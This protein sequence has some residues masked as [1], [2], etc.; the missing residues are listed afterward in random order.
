VSSVSYLGNY[1]FGSAVNYY[2][3]AFAR[4][5]QSRRLMDL[6]YLRLIHHLALTQCRTGHLQQATATA[7]EGINADPDN[8][9]FYYDLACVA[10]RSRDPIGAL[11]NLRQALDLQDNVPSGAEAMD[12]RRDEAF[13]RLFRDPKFR[14]ELRSKLDSMDR[15]FFPVPGS[16]DRVAINLSTFSPTAWDKGVTDLTHFRKIDHHYAVD[17]EVTVQASHGPTS[18]S[19]CLDVFAKHPQ[20]WQHVRTETL[21]SGRVVA[22]L[23]YT[24]LVRTYGEAPCDLFTGTFFD[25]SCEFKKTLVS[26][27]ALDSA[28]AYVVFSTW[29]DFQAS[30]RKIFDQILDSI[31]EVSGTSAAASAK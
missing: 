3:E 14:G 18:V 29:S 16:T 24:D 19:D 30:Q 20:K 25:A 10:G 6:L 7:N 4:E 17:A 11:Q 31:H 5:K 12:P 13:D 9:L 1:N 28:Y 21:P 27:S 22:L 2:S 15:H 23:E 26:C 8:P